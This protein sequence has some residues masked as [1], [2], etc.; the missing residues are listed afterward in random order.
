MI[1]IPR[2]I[3]DFGLINTMRGVKHAFNAQHIHEARGKGY[4]NYGAESLQLEAIGPTKVWN[5]LTMANM[6]KYVNLMTPTENFNRIASAHAGQLYFSQALSTLRGE[7]TMFRMGTNK[8]RMERLMENLWHLEK[9]EI[10]FLKE[11]VDFSSMK[12][13]PQYQQ[14][15]NKVGHFSHVSSQGGTSAVLLPLWMSSKEAKP[16]TLF[17]RMAMSTTIDSYNNFVKPIKEFGNVM[18]LARAAMAHAASGAALY[19][20]YDWVFGKEAPKGSALKQDDH[21]S[22]AML[23]LW[24]SEFLGVFGEVMSPYDRGLSEPIM[25]PIVL[26]NLREAG[27]E[28]MQFMGEGK[29][30]EQASKDFLKKTVVVYNQFGETLPKKIA[31]PY[32][33]K[34]KRLKVMTR[35]FKQ[36]RGMG[37]FSA[38]GLMSRRSPYY[39]NL[40][41][42]LLFGSDE[43]IAKEYWKA[44]NF[45]VTDIEQQNPYTTPAKRAKDAKR[46]I[47]SV[48]SHFDPL[49]LSDDPK[50]TKKS[51]KKQFYDWLEP[52]NRQMAKSMEREYQYLLRKYNR[53]ISKAK[54]KNKYSVY[55][56]M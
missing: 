37:S 16:L 32:W 46:A 48:I 6:F 54:H 7:K 18:P 35:K 11:G 19:Q 1:G 13:L 56:Y 43:D 14:I 22:K 49:N 36:Q 42:A 15:M 27:T 53:I 4:L 31:S 40:K 17:Q 33:E 10:K 26:K 9:G 5:K 25:T 21:F 23:N 50:G 12:E 51:V 39:R 8:K 3:G 20:V 30:F 24:R 52:G 29:T 47:K 38:Q 2:S 55:P 34:M 41:D 28:F 44:F 45:V